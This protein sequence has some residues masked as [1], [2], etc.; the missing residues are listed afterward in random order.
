MRF[1]SHIPSCDEGYRRSRSWLPGTGDFSQ[2]HRFATLVPF[3]MPVKS[4][5]DL[6]EVQRDPN[7]I[8][9]VIG[10]SADEITLDP[11]KPADC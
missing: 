7:V 9:W 10:A 5:R 11:S 3:L 8:P 2:A 6:P 4:N 1:Q